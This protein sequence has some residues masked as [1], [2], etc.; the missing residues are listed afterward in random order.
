MALR[1]LIRQVPQQTQK[2]D[3]ES[4]LVLSASRFRSI[5]S[6]ND[7]SRRRPPAPRQEVTVMA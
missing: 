3:L 2:A 6:V 7:G 1:D 5:E 4:V